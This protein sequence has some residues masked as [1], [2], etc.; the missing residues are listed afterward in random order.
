MSTNKT[1]KTG[2]GLARAKRRLQESA[3]KSQLQ[4]V[5]TQRE[6]VQRLTAKTEPVQKAA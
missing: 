1:N 2:R 5:A 6:A 4:N 3:R